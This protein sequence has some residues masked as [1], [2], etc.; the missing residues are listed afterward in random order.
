MKQIALV[1][2]DAL[3]VFA[4]GMFVRAH[5]KSKLMLLAVRKSS[6]KVDVDFYSKERLS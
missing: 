2:I 5:R 1:D 4:L 6:L 3:F